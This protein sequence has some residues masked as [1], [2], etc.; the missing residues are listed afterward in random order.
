MRPTLLSEMQPLYSRR[1]NSLNTGSVAQVQGNTRAYQTGVATIPKETPV[2]AIS[3][4][5]GNS[6]HSSLYDE[7]IR[8]HSEHNDSSY[9]DLLNVEVEDSRALEVEPGISYHRLDTNDNQASPLVHE[10]QSSDGSDSRMSQSSTGACSFASTSTSEHYAEYSHHQ[11]LGPCSSRSLMSRRRSTL[12]RRP[13]ICRQLFRRDSNGDDTERSTDE[14]EADPKY[15]F[16]SIGHARSAPAALLGAEEDQQLNSVK[17]AI[18][19]EGAKWGT[20]LR[21]NHSAPMYSEVLLPSE[22]TDPHEPVCMI[23]APSVKSTEVRHQHRLKPEGVPHSPNTQIPSRQLERQSFDGACL[24]PFINSR[25]GS[26]SLVQPDE[27]AP[28]KA[29]ATHSWSAPQPTDAHAPLTLKSTPVSGLLDVLSPG[30]ADT[31]AEASVDQYEAELALAIK[32]SLE[33][34]SQ[35]MQMV[36]EEEGSP[37][38]GNEMTTGMD[39]PKSS[40]MC[41]GIPSPLP[42]PLFQLSSVPSFSIFGANDREFVKSQHHALRRFEN[43]PGGHPT[44]VTF[45]SSATTATTTAADDSMSQGVARSSAIVQQGTRETRQAVDQGISQMVKCQNCHR[46]LQ[47]AIT[48]KL[49]YC[50]VCRTVS[51]C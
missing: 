49:V 7:L 16:P 51:P 13:P 17:N 14:M 41:R 35:A 48:Y 25:T 34:A 23:P 15:F 9:F 50:P 8:Y 39:E 21:S 22:L 37:M 24:D 33:S 46:T 29:S 26:R 2:I 47:V 18:R 11:L 30:K 42:P 38:A 31:T 3:P 4:S 12:K 19:M 43:E 5:M 6:S 45:S 44:T 27:H 28:G 20:T 32:L 10:R 1:H 40:E 36:N